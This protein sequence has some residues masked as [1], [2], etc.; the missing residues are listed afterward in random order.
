MLAS[1]LE[2]VERLIRLAE[3]L[4]LLSRSHGRAGVA[5]RAASSS[6]RSCSRCSRSGARLGAGP[7]RE[8]ARR[9]TRRPPA[10]LGDAGALRRALLNLVENGVK[11]T[12]AGRQGGARRSRR[13]DGE[14][15]LAVADTGIGIEP[16]DAERDLRAR[17]SA[18]TPPARERP[19]AA[20]S[21]SPSRA[22]SSSPIAA[23][24]TVESRPGRRSRFTIRLPS[25]A[26]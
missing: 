22:R 12:P 19:A 1:S 13:G 3:D 11:Y 6:S 24:L 7:R 21:A 26:A 2:E 14:A 8:R 15:E 18:W 20:G 5:P 4:L 23:R 16:A 25:T 10:V 9:A 17:S